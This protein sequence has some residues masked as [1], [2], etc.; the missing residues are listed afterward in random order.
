MNRSYKEATIM[1]LI[2][3]SGTAIADALKVV[4]KA[5]KSIDV[6][7]NNQVKQFNNKKQEES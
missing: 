2:Q 3:V 1:D 6:A 4:E 7:V 5:N